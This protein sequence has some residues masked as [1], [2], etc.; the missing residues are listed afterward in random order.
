MS[1]DD[2]VTIESLI[3]AYPEFIPMYQDVYELCRNIERVMG[4]FSKELRELDRNTVQLMIDEMQDEIN[5]QR[6]QLN[7]KNTQLNQKDAQ[8]NQKDA[9]IQTKDRRIEELEKLLA[10]KL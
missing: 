4:L 2:P 10:E 8:L 9:I 3:Q 6:E 7:Q 5:E 1:T